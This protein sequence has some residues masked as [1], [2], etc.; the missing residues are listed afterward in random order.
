VN[1]RIGLLVVACALVSGCA[2]FTEDQCRTANW[3]Y[4]GEQDA[5]T[6]GLQPQIDQIVHQCAKFGVQVPEQQYMRGWYD[7]DRYRA[8]S[9]GRG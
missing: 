7:G 3:Y 6:H 8:L 9:R 1:R 4:L 5:R 2:S